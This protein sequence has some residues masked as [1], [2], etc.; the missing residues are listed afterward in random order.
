MKRNRPIDSKLSANRDAAWLMLLREQ[1]NS[2]LGVFFWQE[3][4]LT[5]QQRMK[6]VPVCMFPRKDKMSH[7]VI[8][9][10][11]HG[12]DGWMDGWLDMMISAVFP[13][14]L[15]LCFYDRYYF[16]Y[17]W[18]VIAPIVVSAAKLRWSKLGLT[19]SLTGSFSIMI[20]LHWMKNMLLVH[21]EWERWEG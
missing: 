12:G 14:L 19:S 8:W 1:V 16:C 5:R 3:K 15:V 7:W 17:C 18:V 10:R 9:F 21:E 4:M 2:F 20:F 6:Y 11:G 13:T